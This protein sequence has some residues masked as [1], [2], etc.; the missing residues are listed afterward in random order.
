MQLT[1]F[2]QPPKLQTFAQRFEH[3][4]AFYNRVQCIADRIRRSKLQRAEVIHRTHFGYEMPPANCLHNWSIV[5]PDEQLSP[6]RR[7]AIRVYRQCLALVDDWSQ[8]HTADKAQK[9]VWKRL[10]L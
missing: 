5:R 8:H 4:K 2:H 6:E 1:L 3:W 10:G 7:A 9:R